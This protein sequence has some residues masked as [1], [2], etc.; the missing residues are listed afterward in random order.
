MRDLAV[1]RRRPSV[2]GRDW[3]IVLLR[4]VV[5]VWKGRP[6]KGIYW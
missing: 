4:S 5:L 3:S 2:V 6:I 1:A